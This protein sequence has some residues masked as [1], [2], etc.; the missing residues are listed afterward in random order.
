MKKKNTA[1]VGAGWFGRAHVRNF[2]ELSHLRA[3]CEVDKSKLD[4]V[5][6]L[7]D[8]VNIYTEVDELIKSEDLDAVSIVT[9]PEFIPVIAKKFADSGIDV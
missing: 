3:V 9:P 6:N 2:Y 7:Y 4:I 8:E 5:Q 1:V